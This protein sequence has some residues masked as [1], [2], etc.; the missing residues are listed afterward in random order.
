MGKGSR[1][2]PFEVEKEQFS[3]NWDSI[4]GKKEKTTEEKTTDSKEPE[5]E[6][7]ENDK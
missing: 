3:N 4:F 6:Q 2:R 5:K 1:A 7:S